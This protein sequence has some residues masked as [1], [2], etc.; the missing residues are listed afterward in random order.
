[1]LPFSVNETVF[2]F[3]YMDCLSILGV[4]KV[5]PTGLDPGQSS[6]RD[7]FALWKLQRNPY[8]FFSRMS[9][10][11]RFVHW[12]ARWPKM[13]HRP[14]AMTRPFISW[15]VLLFVNIFSCIFERGQKHKM[16]NL[17]LQFFSTSQAV[18]WPF[19]PFLVPTSQWGKTEACYS[20]TY[21]LH[22]V[23]VSF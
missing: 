3:K 9:D 2:V 6:P 1:M 17:Q 20:C 14:S 18:I 5:R 4:S 23:S 16:Q 12:R 22:R 19:W 11:S 10:S 8:P 21:L 7:D 13:S 15:Y